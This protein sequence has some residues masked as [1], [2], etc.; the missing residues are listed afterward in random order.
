[1]QAQGQTL[2]AAGIYMAQDF[3]T[4]GQVY[5]DF[6][7]V[8]DPANIKVST[9]LLD[10]EFINASAGAEEEREGGHSEAWEDEEY[11]LQECPGVNLME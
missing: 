8:G 11:C 5:V 6:S 7:R 1:M 3:F 2:E 10:S 4:H 9:F